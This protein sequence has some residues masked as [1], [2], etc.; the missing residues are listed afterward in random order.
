MSPQRQPRIASSPGGT[1]APPTRS[2]YR[3]DLW[4]V[5]PHRAST[6]RGPS[7]VGTA[8]RPPSLGLAGHG[9]PGTAPLSEDWALHIPSEDGLEASDDL[10]HAGVRLDRSNCRGHQVHIGVL[11]LRRELLQRSVDGALIS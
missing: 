7:T 1:G 10:A 4:V 5:W 11:R 3:D 2:L 9:G 6:S 8:S